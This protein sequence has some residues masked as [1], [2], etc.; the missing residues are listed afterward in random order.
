MAHVKVMEADVTVK[1]FDATKGFGFFVEPMFGDIFFHKSILG[2]FDPKELQDGTSAVISFE[3]APDGRLKVTEIHMMLFVKRQGDLSRF[4]PAPVTEAPAEPPTP[5]E[6]VVLKQGGHYRGLVGKV[7]PGY[8]FLKIE[9]V[10]K[11]V[12][13]YNSALPDS[14]VK[15]K[16]GQVYDFTLGSNDKGPAAEKMVLVEPESP[17]SA[18]TAVVVEVAPVVNEVVVPVEVP[19][20]KVRQTI[21]RSRRKV[22]G[23]KPSYDDAIPPAA[24]VAPQ[25]GVTLDSLAGLQCLLADPLLVA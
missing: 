11:F 25:D 5:V 8:G 9:G 18:E 20:A 7:M 17:P 1:W 16:I 15:P 24:L 3:T 19:K 21:H 10:G 23:G 4:I 14:S 22:N 13:F 12:F 2:T 6:E